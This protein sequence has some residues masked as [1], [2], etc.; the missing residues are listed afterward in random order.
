[1]VPFFIAAITRK[2]V[3]IRV[4]HRLSDEKPGNK[5]GAVAS[6]FFVR[7]RQVLVRIADR[8][9]TVVYIVDILN[10][11]FRFDK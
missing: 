2:L 4:L 6:A 5:K 8:T 9:C 11:R 10:T 1:M 7:D 3:A